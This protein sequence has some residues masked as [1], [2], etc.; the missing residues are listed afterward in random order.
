MRQVKEMTKAEGLS[1][2]GEEPLLSEGTD[3]VG[4]ESDGTA[5]DA[6]EEGKVPPSALNQMG[7]A[8][9]ITGL[10]IARRREKEKDLEE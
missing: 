5:K 9:R 1:K 7:A 2:V 4:G 8:L 10:A 3:G 6:G